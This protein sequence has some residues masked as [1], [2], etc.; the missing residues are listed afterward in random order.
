MAKNPNNYKGHAATGWADKGKK[1]MSEIAA[2][3]AMAGARGAGSPGPKNAGGGG[4]GKGCGPNF[5]NDYD[6]M[7]KG[8]RKGSV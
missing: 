3:G 5:C 2:D 6:T 1:A 4:K 8:Y 7:P